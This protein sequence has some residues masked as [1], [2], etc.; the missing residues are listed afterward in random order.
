MHEYIG[1]KVVHAE[2]ETKHIAQ[3]RTSSDPHN[4]DTTPSHGYKVVHNKGEPHERISWQPAIQF[5]ENYLEVAPG[6]GVHLK[7]VCALAMI[8]A[9]QG[10]ELPE[11]ANEQPSNAQIGKVT[12]EHLV[13]VARVVHN[14]TRE[15]L[16]YE[17]LLHRPPF[18]AC[19]LVLQN[20]VI[21]RVD[22]IVH[23]HPYTFDGTNK[24]E[25]LKDR[26]AR[27]IIQ[28]ILAD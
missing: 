8:A 23:G 12:Q 4:S 28:S 10:G 21:S 7:G 26:F 11:P 24:V 17:K 18:D 2:P 13:G 14:V 9:M 3:G 22:A 15:F 1:I 25:V 20:A 5:E 16:V 6:E 19:P 27:I